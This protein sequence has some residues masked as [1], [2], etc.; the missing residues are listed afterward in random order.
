MSA[1]LFIVRCIFSP[2]VLF[3]RIS[4]TGLLSIIIKAYSLGTSTCHTTNI[5]IRWF[6]C[7]HWIKP[8]FHKFPINDISPTYEIFF[9]LDKLFFYHLRY[10]LEFIISS[11]LRLWSISPW[12][13]SIIVIHPFSFSTIY[14]TIFNIRC[15]TR[16]FISISCIF[17]FLNELRIYNKNTSYKICDIQFSR[18]PFSSGI[19][20]VYFGFLLDWLYNIIR[21]LFCQYFLQLI[22]FIFHYFILIV[23]LSDFSLFILMFTQYYTFSN[24]M[25]LLTAYAFLHSIVN[26]LSFT[27]DI[28]LCL[29]YTSVIFL[30]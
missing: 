18:F 24:R 9:I 29:F 12:Y 28:P 19:L 30:I 6:Y 22:L 26:L 10:K 8:P 1:V 21:L 15:L 23:E 16:Y 4:S 14:F 25:F 5:L 13:H 27:V 7:V 3:F 2:S 20:F 11:L 17:R